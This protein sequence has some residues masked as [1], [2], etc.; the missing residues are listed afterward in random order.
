MQSE[1]SSVALDMKKYY[2]GD[3]DNIQHVVRVYTLSKTIGE[4]EKLPEETQLYLELASILHEI[5]SMEDIHEILKNNRI[6]E[7]IKERVCY[8]IENKKNYDHVTG[9]DQQILIE[10]DFIVHIKE[11]NLPSEKIIE[12]GN[13]YFFTNYGKAFLKKAFKI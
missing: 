8:I 11:D 1:I 2:K 10:A 7:D 12:I 5:D 6:D 4:L 13:K 9:L 3:I